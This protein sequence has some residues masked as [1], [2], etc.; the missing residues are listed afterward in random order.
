MEVS[1]TRLPR[2]FRRNVEEIAGAFGAEPTIDPADLSPLL[3]DFQERLFRLSPT[4]ARPELLRGFEDPSTT[5]VS[6]RSGDGRLQ[7][8]ALATIDGRGA[9]ISFLHIEPRHATQ[10]ATARLLEEVLQALPKGVVRVRASDRVAH[11]WTH[12]GAGDA[13]QVLIDHGFAAFDRVLLSRDLTRPVPPPPPLPVG[14]ALLHPDPADVGALA[15]FAYLA[16]RGTTDFSII[17]PDASPESYLR[18]YRR[19]LGGELGLYSPSLSHLLVGPDGETAGVVHT[20]VF[21][22]DPYIGDLSVAPAHRGSGLGRLLLVRALLAYREAGH[23]R[24]GLTVTLQNTA[25]YNLYRSLGF[26]VERSAPVY[27]LAR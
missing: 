20:I 4:D 7:G 21:G 6:W 12:L 5:K 24:T 27:L 17:T 15:D 26:D 13:R 25:A 23:T 8:A 19:F 10:L 2:T 1:P 11:Q 3:E 14:F 16:Y 22:R 9:D 18:L